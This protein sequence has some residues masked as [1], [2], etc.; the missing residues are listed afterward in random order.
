MQNCDSFAAVGATRKTPKQT[1]H[2]RVDKQTKNMAHGGLGI[3]APVFIGCLG[4][5][6]LYLY[7]VFFVLIAKLYTTT[8]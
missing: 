5:T 6:Y 4:W 2:P 7:L 8:M 3:L 1:K